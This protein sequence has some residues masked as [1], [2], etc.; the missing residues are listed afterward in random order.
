[1]AVREANR[2]L[3]VR[4][5]V[6]P[7]TLERVLLVAT[8]EDDTKTKKALQALEKHVDKLTIIGSYPIGEGSSP[9]GLTHVGQAFQPDADASVRLESLTYDLGMWESLVESAWLG[10]RKSSVQIRPSRLVRGE[11]RGARGK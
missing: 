2:I 4:G 10:A 8:H 11:R 7:S 5:Q 6:L 1:M 3:S 9:S